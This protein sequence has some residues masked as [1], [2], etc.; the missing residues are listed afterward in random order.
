VKERSARHLGFWQGK[1]PFDPNP[2]CSFGEGEPV[3][4]SDGKA[5]TAEGAAIPQHHE[6][7]RL[8]G[9]VVPVVRNP[10]ILSL[11]R[12]HIGHLQELADRGAGAALRI[13]ATWV[14]KSRFTVQ[15]RAKLETVYGRL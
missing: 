9:G 4:F 7:G 5:L 2:T 14:A 6:A 1:R 10:D 11:H 8:A 15:G 12:P 3:A 13:E